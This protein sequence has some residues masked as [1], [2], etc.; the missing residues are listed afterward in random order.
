[1]KTNKGI[2]KFTRALSPDEVLL[3]YQIWVTNDP[4]TPAATDT[5]LEFCDG[6]SYDVA[7]LTVTQVYDGHGEMTFEATAGL[8][9]GNFI[10]SGTG[11]PS[12][13]EKIGLV[14]EDGIL[15]TTGVYTLT[16]D[17]TMQVAVKVT[18][19]VS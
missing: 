4:T 10:D 3:V 19:E 8:T 6:S 11:L 7:Q 12:D 2:M 5:T 15:L 9:E 14:D 16:K 1:M 13:W 18:L 17:N